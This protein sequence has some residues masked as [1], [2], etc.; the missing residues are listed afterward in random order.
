MLAYRM[1][2]LFAGE[3]VCR[4]R[5]AIERAHSPKKTNHTE[6]DYRDRDVPRP[7]RSWTP[8]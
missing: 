5:N 7:R 2:S 1:T 3:C 6:E 8:R 4:C